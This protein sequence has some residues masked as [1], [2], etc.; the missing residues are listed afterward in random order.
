MA[1]ILEPVK[2]Q[3]LED[4]TPG[5]LKENGGYIVV[6]STDSSNPP[7]KL[8]L[9]ELAELIGLYSRKKAAIVG[10]I[11]INGGTASLYPASD[12]IISS[13][14]RVGTG[15]WTLYLKSKIYMHTHTVLGSGC[16][17]TGN[18]SVVYV[19]T[20]L[21]KKWGQ[22]IDEV[23]IYIASGTQRVDGDVKVVIIQDNLEHY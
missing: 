23:E 20:N 22:M 1:D 19:G 15:V 16:M 7:Q 3:E 13:A 9:D 11:N 14:N 6:A 5:A 8:T 2:V 12:N 18:Y 10:S 17:E 4:A 21:T